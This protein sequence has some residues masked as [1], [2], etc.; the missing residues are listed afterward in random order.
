[1]NLNDRDYKILAGVVGQL[2]HA[3]WML[4]EGLKVDKR[5]I[6]PE[7]VR[8]EGILRRQTLKE[9]KNEQDGNQ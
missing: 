7:I 1:M 4:H 8:L 3:Y 2:R 5:F 9:E 6:D